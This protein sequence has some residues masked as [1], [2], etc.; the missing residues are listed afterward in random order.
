S[1][2]DS[3]SDL[4]RFIESPSDLPLRVLLLRGET[5]VLCTKLDHRVADGGAA[6]EY[7]YLLA[8]TYRRL[9]EDRHYFPPVNVDGNRSPMQIAN[10]FGLFDRIRMFRRKLSEDKRR[11]K[12]LGKWKYPVPAS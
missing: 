8:D 9:R 11:F 5:D 1:T 2:S 4:I 12:S 3:Q 6:K 10:L 7:L